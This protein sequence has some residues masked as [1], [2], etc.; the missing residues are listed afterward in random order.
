MLWKKDTSTFLFLV[1]ILGL[2][3]WN[4]YPEA[5]TSRKMVWSIFARIRVSTR[6]SKVIWSSLSVYRLKKFSY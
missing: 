5:R 4:T 6:D 1:S 2:A 3:R